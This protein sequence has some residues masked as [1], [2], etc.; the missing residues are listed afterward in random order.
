M[1]YLEYFLFRSLKKIEDFFV[2]EV[3][4]IQQNSY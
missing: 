1:S 4:N 2:K 3:N